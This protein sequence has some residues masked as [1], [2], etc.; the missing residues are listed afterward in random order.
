MEALPLSQKR[1]LIKWLYLKGVVSPGI[2]QRF[3][4][5]GFLANRVFAV[6]MLLLDV[7]G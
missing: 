5:S 7:D 1:K 3:L 2:S 6:E 4:S